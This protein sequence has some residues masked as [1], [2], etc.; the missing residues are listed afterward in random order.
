MDINRP[1]GRWSVLAHMSWK[2]LPA[3]TV[4]FADLGLRDDREYLVYEFWSKQF[5]GAFRGSFPVAAQAAKETRV[6][7]IREEEDHPQIVSTNRHITQGGVDLVDVRWVAGERRLSGESLVVA[8]DR[9]AITVR[10]PAGFV[11]ESASMDG[12]AAKIERSGEIATVSFVPE[13]TG[14]IA[15]EV[16]F[17]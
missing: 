13:K 7:A 11:L 12:V 17:R 10:V 3:A 5:L 6:F 9:Y 16:K 14:R 15:W 4:R 2:A 8:R 1:F